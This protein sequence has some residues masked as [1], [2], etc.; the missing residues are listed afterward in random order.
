MLVIPAGLI[1]PCVERHREF[2]SRSYNYALVVELEYTP[3]LETGAIIGLQVRPLPGVLFSISELELNN[4][5][6]IDITLYKL[7]YYIV[8]I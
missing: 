6:T 3:V 5:V 8:E 4:I 7:Y 1:S 2:D